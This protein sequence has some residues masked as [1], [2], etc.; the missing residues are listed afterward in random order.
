LIA[1]SVWLLA[2]LL[3]AGEDLGDGD[4]H[5]RR[6]LAEHDGVQR[7]ASGGG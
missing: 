5:Q 1:A 4:A 6:A 2:E 3:Q 7:Q